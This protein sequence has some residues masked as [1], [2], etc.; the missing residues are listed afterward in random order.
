M[1]TSQ[2]MSVSNEGAN[3]LYLK[4]FSLGLEKRCDEA[5]TCIRVSNQTVIPYF[6]C[7]FGLYL[8]MFIIL[9]TIESIFN[10]ILSFINLNGWQLI[11]FVGKNY[12]SEVFPTKFN[13]I[14]NLNIVSGDF[15][16]MIWCLCWNIVVELL[17]R[18][19]PTFLQKTIG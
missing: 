8:Q 10:V 12:A 15:V 3:S 11:L 5:Y 7:L 14:E 9:F 13:F 4:F 17:S 18:L 1:G 16:D 19:I 2:Y 6:Y